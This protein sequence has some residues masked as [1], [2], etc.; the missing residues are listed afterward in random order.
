MA[1]LSAGELRKRPGRIETF[2]SKLK[3]GSAFATTPSGSIIGA[4]V[5]IDGKAF[6]KDETVKII[7]ALQS[8]TKIEIV[9]KTGDSTP[10]S[11]ILKSSEFGGSGAA[12]GA[13]S[14][15]A[16]GNRGDMAEA[17][18]A[19]AIT[20]RFMTRNQNISAIHIH[21][22]LDKLQ[23]NVMQQV[24][25]YDGLN[26]NP[27]VIDKVIMRVGLAIPNLIAL[28]DR[29]IRSSLSD[30]VQSAIK[31]ANSANVVKW[32]KMLY[33]NNQKNIIEIIADGIGDQ[34]GTKVDVRLKIDGIPTDLNVSLKAGDV[35]QFGQVGGSG[36]DKQEYLWEK[37][38]GVKVSLI[39]ADYVSF[40]AKKQALK[41]IETSYGAAASGFNKAVNLSEKTAYQKFADGINFFG[42]L[43]E[44]NVTLVQLN[45]EEA[46]IYNFGA[47]YNAL[48]KTKTK[49]VAKLNTSKS[50][51]EVNFTNTAGEILLTVRAK[52]ENKANGEQ[53]IR[54]YVEKGP[55]MGKLVASYA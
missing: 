32:A 2:A 36:F 46:K 50:Y 7:A 27:K 35:K 25:E 40:L 14:G 12:G 53:Y 34:T 18:F 1:N 8:A 29:M 45:K 49:L 3:Q 9:S 48:Q 20:A 6:D 47:L 4:S 21:A 41:A 15:G 24:H 17:I 39:E 31:Y 10:I 42:T 28:Q 22:L 23:T 5:V 37:L 38:T 54:N 19:A 52:T 44:E 13:S 43:H 51:P 11:K 26:Q 33:E 30:I 16:K 55:L